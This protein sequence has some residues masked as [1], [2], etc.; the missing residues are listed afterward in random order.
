LT[1]QSE[2]L[3]ETTF[4]DAALIVSY[5]GPEKE[6]EVL[7]FIQNV[8]HGRKLAAEQLE[9]VVKKYRQIGNHSP[10]NEEC[11]ALISG[12]L[13]N[14]NDENII[15]GLPNDSALHNV[16]TRVKQLPIYW[17]NLFWRPALDETIAE[18]INEGIRRIF[19]F[20]TVP[21]ETAHR[22]RAY[23]QTLDVT[24]QN[25]AKNAKIPID[26][27]CIHT[28]RRF[29]NHPLYISAVADRL[30]ETFAMQMDWKDKIPPRDDAS[31]I[32]RRLIENEQDNAMVIFTAHSLT[33]ADA[34]APQSELPYEQ[35]FRQASALVAETLRLK[36]F[37]IEWDVAYQSRSVKQGSWSEPDVGEFVK[38][39][40]ERFPN[41]KNLYFCPIGFMLENT[42]LLYDLDMEI[43]RLCES[44]GLQYARTLPVGGS[45]KAIA[46]IRELIA[47]KFSPLVPRR[48]LGNF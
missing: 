23:L 11:R 45:D 37:G 27:I 46:M 31:L 10:V 25:A 29:Y 35:Q 43:R 12:L 26:D 5:G 44:L 30:T 24:A 14:Q 17:G 47:E 7:P 36:Q 33:L 40:P 21:F 39:L 41:R 28:A 22:K 18:M 8:L 4:Y 3:N 13:R 48:L 15:L 16:F 32:L 34:E 6:D 42:E 9:N 2:N 1:F 38:T 20:C 19:A